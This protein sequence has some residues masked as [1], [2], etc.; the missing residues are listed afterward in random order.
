MGSNNTTDKKMYLIQICR[1]FAAILVLL[2]HLT[3]LFHTRTNYNYLGGIFN[4]GNSGV[5]FFFVLSGF[6]IFYIHY[7]DIGDPE[8][9]KPFLIKRFIRVYPIYWAVLLLIIPIYFFIPLFGDD[10]IRNSISVLRAFTLIPFTKGP[11]PFLVVAW[12]MSYEVLFYLLFSILISF[13]RRTSYIVMFTWAVLTF[14]F[15]FQV[16]YAFGLPNNYIL[17]F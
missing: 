8:R 15:V 12:S 16:P 1:G 13:K 2:F 7:K 4:Q 5:D 3:E 17:N 11:A 14:L 9:L 10:S 6:I